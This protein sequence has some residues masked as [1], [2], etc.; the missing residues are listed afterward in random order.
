[1]MNKSMIKTSTVPENRFEIFARMIRMG[2]FL[3]T[4]A[5]IIKILLCFKFF[6]SR[7]ILL[8]DFN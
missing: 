1:M 4:T 8:I 7:N 6:S 5:T 2:T 3:E